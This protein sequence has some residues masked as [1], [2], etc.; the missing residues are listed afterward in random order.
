MTTPGMWLDA[1]QTAYQDLN[2]LFYYLGGNQTLTGAQSP[3][4]IPSAVYDC[5]VGVT[6]GGTVSAWADARTFTQG[7]VVGPTFGVGASGATAPSQAG[8]LGT[9]VIFTTGNKLLT[10]ITSIN[11]TPL[12]NTLVLV[13]NSSATASATFASVVAAT[14]VLNI[15]TSSGPAYQ[16]VVGNA[17]TTTVSTVT[18]T[19]GPIKVLAAGTITY[20]TGL[21]YPYVW[22]YNQPLFISPSSITITSATSTI[23]LG[24][25]TAAGTAFTCSVYAAMIFPVQLTVSQLQLIGSWA[26]STFGAAAS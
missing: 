18:A 19:S 4:V 7:G 21:I 10:T 5:R 15:G 12:N 6:G 14:P 13:A 24:G 23:Q 3:P 11:Y 25:A 9:P 26:M 20:N 17:P 16:S 2:A 1:I 22:I 8:G